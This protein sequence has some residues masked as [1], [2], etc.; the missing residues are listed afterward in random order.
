MN[1]QHEDDTICIEART[2][3]RP[4]EKEKPFLEASPAIYNFMCTLS[5]KQQQQWKEPHLS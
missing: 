4:S 2:K 5:Q 3:V 1:S